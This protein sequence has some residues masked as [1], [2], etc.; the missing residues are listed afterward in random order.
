MVSP[1]ASRSSIGPVGKENMLKGSRFMSNGLVYGD[2]QKYLVALI[3]LNEPEVR[4]WAKTHGLE[5]SGLTA[6][7]T[8]DKVVELIESEIKGVN[9]QLASYESIKKFRI[10][11]QDFTVETGELTPSL[12]IKRKVCVAK[13]DSFIKDMY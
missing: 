4:Q 11:P 6:M 9:G 5:I 8:H 10:L 13:F 2:K 3:C 7:S 12:K 1:A